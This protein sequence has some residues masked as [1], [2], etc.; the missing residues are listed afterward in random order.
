MTLN[1]P[2]TWIR[3]MILSLII[4][5]MM[6][7]I[8]SVFLRSL[9]WATELRTNQPLFLLGLPFLGVLTVYS[10]RRFGKNSSKGNN[11]IIDS[12]HSNIK[13]PFRMSIL[14]F[15]F[16]I[17]THFFGGSAGREGTGVQIGGTLSNSL[18]RAFNLSKSD[19][20]ILVMS[21]ISAGFASVFGTPLAGAVFGMEVAFI[22]KLST[23]ALIP[24]FIGAYSASMVTHLLGI[25]HTVYAVTAYPSINLTL[26]LIIILS[27]VLF[28]LTGRYFA[29]S[30]HA[31]KELIAKIKLNEL[32]KAFLGAS[33]VISLMFSLNATKFAGLSTWLIQAGFDGKVQLFDPLMKFLLTVLTLGSGFQ[34]GEV[35][36]LF[37]IGSS[38]GG[39]IGQFSGISP[40]L[41]AALGLIAVFGS[42]ANTPLT[43]IMLGI[44]LFGAKALPFYIIVAL[45]SYFASGHH[46]IYT[47]QVIHL[48]KYYPFTTHQ[49]KT[50]HDL[51]KNP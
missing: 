33:L 1:K 12:I 16:T 43:M 27:S 28:G 7:I 35:T 50:L 39:L 5:L 47:S 32:V 49:G 36:P 13:V 25:T 11:L 4:G 37:G 41:L 8:S 2:L 20:R 51:H 15:V 21:G 26:V 29:Q 24:C 14:T 31:L 17:S 46:G 38:L 30:T 19:Q 10:Y 42:A 45:I 22:G 23:E 9:D 44:D 40:S 48:G 6:G 34:G 18:S 3:L